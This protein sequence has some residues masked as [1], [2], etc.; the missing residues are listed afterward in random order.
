[1]KA[2]EHT[3]I[4]PANYATNMTMIAQLS[5]DQMVNIKVF[6]GNELVGAAVPMTINEEKFYFLTISSD[7]TGELRFE[8][9]SGKRLSVA[10]HQTIRYVADSH[11]G[12]LEKPILLEPDNDQRPY[13]MIE[14]EHVV[15]IKNGEKYDVTGKKL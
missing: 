11:H 5:N 7:A 6:M 4:T 12:S 15:I 8:T 13:K 1:M 14:N 10:G 3:I 9:E 2:Q